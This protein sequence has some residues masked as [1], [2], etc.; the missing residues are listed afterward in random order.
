MVKKP[1]LHFPDL[2]F[3]RLCETRYGINRGVFNTIDLWFFEQGVKDIIERR[4]TILS[5]LEINRHQP[6]FGHGGLSAR[7][8]EYYSKVYNHKV[9]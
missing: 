4:K 9:S 5:F 3:T 2:L 1:E 6:P 8:K 7:L